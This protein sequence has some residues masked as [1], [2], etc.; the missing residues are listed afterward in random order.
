[1]FKR[2]LKVIALC[3]AATIVIISVSVVPVFAKTVK[4][5]INV[6]YNN[7]KIMF[8]GEAVDFGYE[9]FILNGRTYLPVRAVAEYLG[10]TVSWDEAAHTVHISGNE[11]RRQSDDMPLNKRLISQSIELTVTMGSLAKS[12]EYIK[13]L[14]L[15]PDINDF[16]TK[17]G[18]DDYTAPKKAVLIKVSD[19]S[20][21]SIIEKYAGKLDLP[22]SANEILVSRMFMFLPNYVNALQGAGAITAASMLSAGK[23]LRLREDFYDNTYVILLYEN[24]SS[25]TCMRK[26]G[27]DTISATSTFLFLN[28]EMMSAVSDET[29]A[30]YIRKQLGN[31]KVGIEYI[32]GDALIE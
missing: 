21:M 4:D 20:L 30:E 27:E 1:M 32:E 10:Y 22:E 3:I 15:Q 9:P 16:V 29:I 17:M 31:V 28:E 11:E 24:N 26:N 23:T 6:C 19:E 8:N 12:D 7:I 18:D 2:K 14:S 5:T 25:I 13:L